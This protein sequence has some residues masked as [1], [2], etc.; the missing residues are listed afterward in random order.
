M[1]VLV[2]GGAGFIGYHCAKA[3]LEQGH[4]VHVLDNVNDYYNPQIKLARIKQLEHFGRFSFQKG[5]LE[6][7]DFVNHQF[8]HF[9]PEKVLHL[10]AQAGVRYS[11][12]HPHA[13]VQSNVV[14]FVNILEACRHFGKP[15][16]VYASSSSVYGG[17]TRLPFS[18]SDRVDTPISLYA[19]TKKA[20]EL[21]AHTYTH[22]Y[23]M[24]TVGLRF[25]TV[26]GP[27]GR[28]DMAMWLFADAI[29]ADRPIQVFNHGDMY[30]DFTYIDDIVQGTLACLN[31][32]QIA[33]Y[34]VFNL[35]NHRS[36]HLL[37][38]IDLI[39]QTLGKKAKRELL[40]MQ[41]G[42]VQSTYA[43]IEH[44]QNVLGFHP[45]TPIQSGVPQFLKWF[46]EH[47]EFHTGR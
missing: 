27:W 30:R 41:P 38:L 21:M 3:L 39:E 31:V 40:P 46:V 23:A 22:L 45:T 19:A 25:F 24:E 28:P 37:A 4:S 32:S 17:N 18:V 11:L 20:N 26:Y 10:A 33:P 44:A 43:D 15:R 7:A 6:N 12:T 35:G 34:E 16:L 42:D 2:T 47:P 13:Y 29:L 14:A 5:P 36:E 8:A 1:K 9:G